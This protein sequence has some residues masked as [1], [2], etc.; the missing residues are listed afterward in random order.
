MHGDALRV[1]VREAPERGAANA[2]CVRDLA[3]VL[4]VRRRDVELEASTKSRRKRVRITGDR[5]AIARRLEE[6]ARRET[7]MGQGV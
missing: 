2:A 4:G 3:R 5:E 1:A 6:L 7:P